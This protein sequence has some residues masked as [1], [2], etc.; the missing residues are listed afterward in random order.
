MTVDVLKG[1]DFL[2]YYGILPRRGE[3]EKEQGARE[4]KQ[5]S[6]NCLKFHTPEFALYLESQT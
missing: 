6:P 4:N 1:K 3:R 2:K 5:I